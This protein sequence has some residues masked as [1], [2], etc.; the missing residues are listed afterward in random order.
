M[1]RAL[2]FDFDGL[3]LETEW[4]MYQAWA[5]LY[6]SFGCQIS[7]EGWVSTIG[8]DEARY[9]PHLD[10]ER[11][12]GHLLD[13]PTL[14]PWRGQREREL[15]AGLD[16]RPG[17]E[18]YLT[19]AQRLGLKIGLASSSSRAWVEG[20]LQQRGLLPCFDCLCTREDVIRVK[21]DP[22]L[23]R[24]A[25]EKLAVQGKEAI[26]FED[27]MH[28]M[29]AARQAGLFCVVVP[30]EFTRHLPLESADLRLNSL[31]E[32]PLEQLLARFERHV[33]Q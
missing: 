4:A 20:H 12:V 1:I 23:Y 6:Q 27:S 24:L 15:V 7:M 19:G 11:Q 32:L 2:I 33:E 3:I 29:L 26:A 13:W 18:A 8:T 30:I 10:L 16:L 22:A 14:T 17:V 28:G 25:L 9:D 21:P 31:A 5:E